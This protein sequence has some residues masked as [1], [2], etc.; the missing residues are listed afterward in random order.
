MVFL[1]TEV[2]LS[3]DLASLISSTH[4]NRLGKGLPVHSDSSEPH[5]DDDTYKWH[6]SFQCQYAFE[7]PSVKLSAQEAQ[8]CSL[9]D[10]LK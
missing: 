9:C 4:A 5:V 2:D 6:D 3:T 8:G 1:V 10:D 7:D